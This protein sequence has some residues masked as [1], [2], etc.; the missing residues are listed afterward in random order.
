MIDGKDIIGDLSVYAQKAADFVTEVT[1]E[2]KGI[3]QEQLE[4]T[5]EQI[6]QLAIPISTTS[7]WHGLMYSDGTFD[8][9]FIAA[10]TITFA[11][12]SSFS[13]GYKQNVT[14]TVPAV[15]FSQ[16]NVTLTVSNS[17]VD[18]TPA[19]SFGY[20][21]IS[22]TLLS[23]STYQSPAFACV[24]VGGNGTSISAIAAIKAY[25]R[26]TWV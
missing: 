9:H 24:L 4:Q 20:A 23:T 11:A 16:S 14:L 8:A 2:N 5:Q 22:K 17:W 12:G 19:N 15:T 3:T 7:G 25:V 13:P 18:F 26:G 6:A 10:Q 1:D 21:V